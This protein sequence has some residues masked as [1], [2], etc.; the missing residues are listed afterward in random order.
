MKGENESL[1]LKSSEIQQGICCIFL[2]QVSRL[3][4]IVHD[5]QLH[6]WDLGSALEVIL[7]FLM[8]GILCL[9]LSSFIMFLLAKRTL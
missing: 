2:D 4:I 5:S 1:G 9:K 8:K 3:G 6:F 7:P